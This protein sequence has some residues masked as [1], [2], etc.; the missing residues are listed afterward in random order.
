METVTKRGNFF[1]GKGSI[2]VAAALLLAICAYSLF[3]YK[4]KQ[5]NAGAGSRK[6]YKEGVT[7]LHQQAVS[8]CDALAQHQSTANIQA[9][10]KTTRLAYKQIEFMLEF[11]NPYT[12]QLLNGPKKEPGDFQQLEN[13]LFPVV[14]TQAA[15]VEAR[16][17]A[18]V[19]GN[20]M[21]NNDKLPTPSDAQLFDAM[22]LELV[23]ILSL[24]LSGFDSPFAQNSLSETAAS[25]EGIQKVWTIYAPQV[26]L[27]NRDLV[28]YTNELLTEARAEL[29][30][31]DFDREHFITMYVNQLSVNLKL[32]REAL[33]I[34]YDEQPCILDPAASNVFAKN[35]IRPLYYSDDTVSADSLIDPVYNINGQHFKASYIHTILE[36]N[37]AFNS[38]AGE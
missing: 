23:R 35:A 30:K 38:Y 6:W 17:L 20:L 2:V 8:L 1:S 29:K 27:R 28:K 5:T 34:A 26:N 14:D 4:S 21:A 32:S 13:L 12:A 37:S 24:G 36:E 19:T 22:R 25:L 33:H 18:S 3:E 16:K 31:T 10:F 11:F 7:Q 15:Y 9:A